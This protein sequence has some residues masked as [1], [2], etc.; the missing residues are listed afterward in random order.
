MF[1]SKTYTYSLRFLR[2]KVSKL[3]SGQN[4]H[5]YSLTISPSDELMTAVSRQWA[6]LL[7]S[8]SIHLISEEFPSVSHTKLLY[9]FIYNTTVLFKL[10]FDGDFNASGKASF[11]VQ[12]MHWRTLFKVLPFVNNTKSSKCRQKLH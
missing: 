9:T 11:I 5:H 4:L 1:W 8:T 6:E 10:Y 3:H 2:R 12:Y 7:S